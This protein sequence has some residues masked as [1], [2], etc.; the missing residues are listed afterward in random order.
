MITVTRGTSVTFQCV[1]DQTDLSDV[2]V[3][4]KI[5]DGK[6]ETVAVLGVVKNAPIGSFTINMV[7]A[8][9]STLPIGEYYLYIKYKKDTSLEIL[10]PLILDIV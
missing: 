9:T 3:T 2:T 4:A 10:E 7:P 5:R 1:A 6:F 8:D